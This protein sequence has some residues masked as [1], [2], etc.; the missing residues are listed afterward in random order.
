MKI[1]LDTNILV[2]GLLNPRGKPATVLRLILSGLIEV[3]ADDRILLEYETVLKRPKF[4]R[5]VKDAEVVLREIRLL[6]ERVVPMPLKVKIPDRADLPFL[7]VARTSGADALVTGNKRH[8]PPGV[9]GPAKVWSSAELL[10]R[11]AEENQ[12]KRN[13][14]R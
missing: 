13:P 5:I 9:R 10:D 2:S 3:A 12:G 7:E 6:A 4:S 1:V 14:S 11:I 8:F